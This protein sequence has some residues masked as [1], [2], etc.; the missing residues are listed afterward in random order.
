MTEMVEKCSAAFFA[1]LTFG[2]ATRMTG[3]EELKEDMLKEARRLAE[4]AGVEPMS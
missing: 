1:G 4:Y 3:N 2:W